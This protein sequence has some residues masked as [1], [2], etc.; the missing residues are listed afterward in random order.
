MGL[1]LFRKGG[2]GP[3]QSSSAARMRDVRTE[4]KGYFLAGKGQY[5]HEVV[6]LARGHSALAWGAEA[7]TAVAGIVTHG[8]SQA[9]VLGRD[10]LA[11]L[12]ETAPNGFACNRIAVH[13]AGEGIGYLPPSLSSIYAEW[14]EDWRL[15]QT[16][17]LCKARVLIKPGKGPRRRPCAQV[18]LDI[19]RPF[20]IRAFGS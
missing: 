20:E 6:R 19:A 18:M 13:I 2:R 1:G 3:A 15:T 8:T 9:R 16:L 5:T 11:R 14:A 7:P 4:G 12:V 10:F 17:I